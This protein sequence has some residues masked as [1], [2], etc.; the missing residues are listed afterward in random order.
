MIIRLPLAL[1]RLAGGQS[2]VSES[3]ATVAELLERLDQRFPGLADRVL[4]PDGALKRHINVFV[5][6]RDVRGLQGLATLLG[7]DDEIVIAAA[8]AGG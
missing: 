4:E 6:G 8:M 3:A 5:N 7:S 1:R 2:T